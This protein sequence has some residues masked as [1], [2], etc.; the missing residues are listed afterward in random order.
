MNHF[1]RGVVR[2]I[3][4]SFEL[5]GPVLEVGSY[6]VEGQEGLINLR[7]LFPGQPY[8][9]L[10]MR[11]GPGVDLVASVESLPLPDRSVG[12][13][14]ALS[15]FEHVRRFWK[16]FEELHRILRPDG[17]LL[18]A[19]PFHFRIHNYPADYWRFTPAALEVLLEPYPSKIIGWHGTRNR[20]ANVWAVAFG[21][22]RPPISAE[23]YERYRELMGRYAH[24]PESSWTRR[25]RYRLGSMLFGKGPFASYL[26]RNCWSC[27]CL[28]EAASSD[29]DRNFPHEQWAE[30]AAEFS[31][32]SLRDA[33]SPSEIV[34][35]G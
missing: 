27:L 14:L 16:G 24:E 25:V 29:D 17:A 35:P 15:A 4:E 23:R 6:Q 11:R 22:D 34:R 3:R 2:A 30:T 20:P 28:N 19:C 32:P 7:S 33:I 13:V 31:K 5:D 21:P 9:G 10:D 12:T 8:T 1:L 18:I 26:D